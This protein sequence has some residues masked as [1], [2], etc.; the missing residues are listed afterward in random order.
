[1]K[2][3]SALV[4]ILLIIGLNPGVAQANVR[5]VVESF[6]F[7]PNDFDLISVNTDVV[8]ELVVSHPSGIKTN[9]TLAS[10]TGPNGNSLATYLTRT[11]LPVNSALNKVTFRGKLTIPQNIAVGAY[12][13]SVAEVSNNSTAGYEYGTGTITPKKLRD[14]VGAEYSLLIRNSGDLNLSYDTFVGPTHNTTLGI[15][16]NDP[17]VYNNNN[18]PIWKVGETYLPSNYFESRIPS[19]ALIVSSSTPTVCST[20]GKELKLIAAGNCTFKVSTAKTKD[21]AVKE[22]VQVVTVAASRSKSELV[23]SVIANQTA[24]GLPKMIEIFRVFSPTGVYVMPQSTTPTVC[25]ASGFY[26][27]IVGGGICTLT[28]QSEANTSYLASDLYKV[29]FD[30]TRDPQ[31][32]SFAPVTTAHIATKSLTLTASASGGGVVTFASTST[33]TCTISGSTLS[34]LKAGNC[35]ITAAQAGTSTFSPVSVNAT[36][37]LTGTVITP[38]QIVTKKTIVCV[39]GKTTKRVSGIKPKCPK[40]WVVK[41]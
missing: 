19:L 15:S 3:K 4:A 33:E 17:S 34:L 5:P 39:K 41:K 20:D 32:I 27:Q 18:P 36:I 28:Y 26:V 25:I 1:M 35:V 24:K 30:V 13:V 38:K 12:T 11:D 40:S 2:I 8:F 37:T 16:Y 29:S 22:I 6:T 31:T 9:S 7:T 14:L 23:M 21:Y 10:L